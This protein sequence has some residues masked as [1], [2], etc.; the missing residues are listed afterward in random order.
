MPHRKVARTEARGSDRTKNGQRETGSRRL[1]HKQSICSAAAA[2]RRQK[3]SGK[4]VS[5][6]SSGRF[7]LKSCQRQGYLN[8]LLPQNKDPRLF[9]MKITNSPRPSLTYLLH[10]NGWSDYEVKASSQSRASQGKQ[11]HRPAPR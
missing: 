3:L 5:S 6:L 9:T 11:A 1:L 10:L 2:P 7:P 8:P 4:E